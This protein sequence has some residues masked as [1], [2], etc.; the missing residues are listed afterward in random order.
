MPD[1]GPGEGHVDDQQAEERGT[2]TSGKQR[3]LLLF[4]LGNFLKTRGE[5]RNGY[6]VF[7]C[8]FIRKGTGGVTIPQTPTP[9]YFQL[10]CEQMFKRRRHR[11]FII[12]ISFMHRGI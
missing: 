1:S 2:T 5:K 10:I 8:L 9:T 7:K 4:N 6:V 11:L 12:I 3:L